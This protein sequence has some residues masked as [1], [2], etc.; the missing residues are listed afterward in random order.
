MND[1]NKL[2]WYQRIEQGTVIAIITG[3]V[4]CGLTILFAE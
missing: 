3:V 2:P 4:I 1:K